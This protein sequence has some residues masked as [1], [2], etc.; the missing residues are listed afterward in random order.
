MTTL[1]EGQMSPGNRAATSKGSLA[2]VRDLASYYMDFLETD[3][4]RRKTPKRSVRF[5][6]ADNLL[7]GI[8]LGRYPSFTSQV[9]KLISSGFEKTDLNHISKGAYRTTIPRELLDLIKLEVEKIS[10]DHIAQIRTAIASAID[11]AARLSR[12]DFETAL[13]V[14]LEAAGDK[15]RAELVLP[16][17]GRVQASLQQADLSDENTIY[18]MEEELRD[19]LLEPARSKISEIV[20]RIIAG[21]SI[22]PDVE[23]QSVF[24]ERTVRSQIS[25]F[26]S[27][28]AV[29]D[30][31]GELYEME[32]NKSILEKQEF[33]LYFGD[34]AH[35][36]TKYPIFYIPFQVTVERDRLLV[37]FDARVYLNKR[38]LAYVVQQENERTGKRGNLKCIAERIIYLSE[39][40][41]H[42]PEL[43]SGYCAELSNF[44]ALDKTIDILNPAAQT[45]KGPAVRITNSCYIALFDNSDEALLNDYE[46]LLQFLAGGS[47]AKLAEAFSGLVENFINH[48]PESVAREVE[49]EWDALPVPDRL[50]YESPIPLNSEQRQILLALEKSRCKY[51]TVEGPPGTGKSHTI[52]A[53]VC[54]AVLKHQSVLVLSDKKEALDVV[55]DKII[56]TLN[57]VRADKQ[58]QNPILRLGK[59]GSTYAQILSTTVMEGIKTH[60]RAVK[61]EHETLEQTIHQSA[62]SLKDDVEA[63]VIAY[64][65]VDV[66]E[67]S[68]WAKLEA[69]YDREEHLVDSQELAEDEE[70]QAELED[71]RTLLLVLRDLSSKDSSTS[72][73]AAALRLGSVQT[74]D[75]LSRFLQSAAMVERTISQVLTTYPH[76]EKTLAL[77]SVISDR[78]VQDLIAFVD[79]CVGLKK[80]LIGYLFAKRH[81]EAL[82][83]KF[84]Q[85]YAFTSADP[86]HTHLA[87]LR[88]IIAIASYVSAENKQASI[89]CDSI[90]LCHRLLTKPDMR[91]LLQW[92]AELADISQRFARLL[93]KYPKS[94]AK[95]G[96]DPKDC[97]TLGENRLTNLSAQDFDRL[98]RYVTL[99]N[100]LRHKFS[101]VPEIRYS[102]EQ[103]RIQDLVTVHMT[104]IMDGQVIEFYENQRN[105]AKA[106]REIIRSKQQ[107]PKDEFGK[108]RQAFP[109]ILAGIRDYAEYIPLEPEIFD[110]LVIDEASQVS[111]AQALPALLR[112]KRILILGDKKQFSNVKAIQARTDTNR[113]YL[114][115]L[116]ACFREHVS[117][118][119]AKLVK[120]ERFNIRSSVLEFFEFISNYN[121]Q[122]L[123]HFRCYKEIISYSNTYFYRRSLQVMKIRG[124]QIDDV[125]RFT[126]L[127][128]ISSDDCGRNRNEAEVKFIIGELLK[129]KAGNQPV[130]VGIITPHTDQQKL[131]VDSIG[132]LPE[133]EYFYRDL[134]L[135]IMTFDTCQGEERDLIYYSMVA[136]GGV[137]H[138]WG[139]FIKDLASIDLEEDGKIKAQRLNVGFSRAKECAHFVLSKPLDSYDGAIGEAL[140]HFWTVRDEA[141]KERSAKEVDEKSGR[142]AEVLNWFYQ[143]EFWRTEKDHSEF[144]PQFEIGKYLK[145]L[146]PLYQHPLYRV[147]FLLVHRPGADREEKIIIEYDGFKEHFGDTAGID[148]SNYQTYYSEEDVYRQKVLESYGYK[149]LR[150]NRFNVGMNPIATLDG[151]IR[152]IVAA[153][154]P[155]CHHQVLQSIHDNYQHLRNGDLRE[156]PKCKQVRPALDFRDA[157]LTSGIGR[158]CKQCKGVRMPLRATAPPQPAAVPAAGP[159]P[160]PR[161]GSKMI[162]RKGRYGRFY[163]CSRFPYCRATH[164]FSVTG[165]A[166]KH[167]D[168]KIAQAAGRKM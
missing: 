112:A 74:V 48:E 78:A 156:C 71:M 14:S 43:L 101:V 27:N 39:Q 121:T 54:Q 144:I 6:N 97:A 111:I 26:F 64:A 21:H 88:E 129:L 8:N 165:E 110:L 143:T 13:N 94:V 75:E 160:C 31:F 41:D 148:A 38:A 7:I 69:H 103:R 154:Q 124:K 126:L 133:R 135:K 104:Y 145:Q 61:K 136:T 23:L 33:Y 68:E 20:R 120:L 82:D 40:K 84:R 114:N 153:N 62:D 5:R 2:F 58:F 53:I 118:D 12:G 127:K 115:R 19:L 63:E 131:L 140:R 146:D 80:P 122:L 107:F 28:L 56:S 55:E 119:R 57:N 90:A 157:S 93:Q 44:F 49:E 65:D 102:D 17:V 45:A 168:E 134:K 96:I 99:N 50:V 52:T 113:E 81:I 132:K 105:T 159:Y 72:A 42:L 106:L 137:D 141:R 166:R 70:S 109:C 155:A 16:F 15:L 152:K 116:T 83:Q 59:T 73:L 25:A 167:T 10:A 164:P 138:L 139:V 66:P 128:D 1:S 30:L 147:D 4:H 76:A 98:V 46:Q 130:S 92:L 150:I 11:G 86:P 34:I 29:G 35:S 142:E 37:E 51:V 18:L 149:F 85:E 3:F 79:K 95:L 60:Y 89:S 9:W 151:R 91:T 125:L 100:Q 24:D 108:L 22:N 47:D 117:Q 123:K 77:V 87:Q 161:C 162:L 67:I 32:R 36:G 158:F 163:G